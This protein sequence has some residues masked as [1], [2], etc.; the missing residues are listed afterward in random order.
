MFKSWDIKSQQTF[1]KSFKKIDWLMDLV[2]NIRSTKVD[3]NVS[4]GSFIDIST[5]ELNSNKTAI[6]ND[7]L[8]VLKRLGRVTNVSHSKLN[9]NGVKIIVDRETV[10]LYFDQNFDLSEQKQKISN[11]VKDLESKIASI[12]KKMKNK[13]FLKNAPKQIISRDKKA[14]IDYG[15]ELKKLNS[16]LNSIKN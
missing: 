11:K 16:I 4:P 10:I 7:N 9:K 1:N 3:L 15:I 12:N 13:S 6:I 5:S 2:T 14:L 8:S